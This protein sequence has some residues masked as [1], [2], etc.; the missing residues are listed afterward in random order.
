MSAD[1]IYS[2]AS[3]T[4]QQQLREWTPDLDDILALTDG[5]VGLCLEHEMPLLAYAVHIAPQGTV[6]ELGSFQ[7][8]TTIVLA[9]IAK[10]RG[11]PMF[12]IDDFKAKER[13]AHPDPSGFWEV[14]MP[15]S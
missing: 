8:Y 1:L 3:E 5:V 15:R 14:P 11:L 4:F 7:G 2:E 6:V 13:S 9:S 12:S 10:R